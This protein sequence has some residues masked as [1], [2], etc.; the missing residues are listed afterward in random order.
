[1]L[2]T[3]FPACR[4]PPLRRRQQDKA[5]LVGQLLAV[6]GLRFRLHSCSGYTC[7]QKLDRHLKTSTT[8]TGPSMT[9]VLLRPSASPSTEEP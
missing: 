6:L 5:V 4:L 2:T 3:T 9:I 7:D 8:K 1:M